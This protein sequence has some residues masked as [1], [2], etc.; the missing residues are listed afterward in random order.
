MI[1]TGDE[2]DDRSL[3]LGCTRKLSEEG[4]VV[5]SS[6]A[7]SGWRFIAR[8]VRFREFQRMVEVAAAINGE[9]WAVA[10]LVRSG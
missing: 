1:F 8:E 7:S 9:T 3:L 4:E 2:E 10:R 6:G 5:L